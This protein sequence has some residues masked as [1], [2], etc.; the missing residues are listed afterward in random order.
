[1]YDA[2]LPHAIFDCESEKHVYVY[3]TFFALSL[4]RTESFH[5]TGFFTDG[6]AHCTNSTSHHWPSP[7]CCSYSGC[8]RS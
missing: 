6:I 1:M 7:C 5:T 4:R 3:G 8:H 2:T